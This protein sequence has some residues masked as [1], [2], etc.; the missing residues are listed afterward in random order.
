MGGTEAMSS[1]LD[2]LF[3]AADGSWALSRAGA[4]HADVSNQPSIGSPWMYLFTGE[5][6]KAQ[7]TVRQTLRQLWNA[8][9]SGIP[10][11]DDLGQMSSWYVFSSL[12]LYPLYPGRGDLVISSP[13]F[14]R[15]EIG[16]ITILA[17][18]ASDDHQYVRSLK[19]NGLSSNRSW[20]GESHLTRPVS[21]EFELSSDPNTSWGEPVE[22]RPPS[23]STQSV[24]GD[25]PELAPAR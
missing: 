4:G 24:S 19:V 14:R 21:L 9:P 3:H 16:N 7:Q 18:N 25:E 1:R 17:D 10:G 13:V 20:I 23:Y 12:G 8:S 11:Q 22:D 15:A 6:H 2:R 5:A